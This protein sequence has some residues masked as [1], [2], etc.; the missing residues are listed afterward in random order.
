MIAD[1]IPEDVREYLLGGDGLGRV[2]VMEQHPG[3]QARL[4]RP[5]VQATLYRYLASQEPWQEEIPALAMAALDALLATP[6]ANGA[7]SVEK[8]KRHPNPGVRVK[9]Y[10]YLFAAVYPRDREAMSSVLVDMLA[11]DSETVRLDAAHFIK[12]LKLEAEMRT[13]LVHWLR[14][15]PERKYDHG[16]SF[17]PSKSSR[18]NRYS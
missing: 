14:L 8:L 9:V 6:T 15:A 10:R 1:E 12:N 7:Q 5:E 2:T 11:D 4:K 3:V 16:E 17:A 18:G 13:L